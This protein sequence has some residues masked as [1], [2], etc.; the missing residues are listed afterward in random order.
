M[1]TEPIYPPTRQAHYPHLSALDSQLWDNYLALGD[2]GYLSVQYDVP[3]GE[4]IDASLLTLPKNLYM[5]ARLSAH[6]IDIVATAKDH[7]DIIECKP[8]AG[9]TALGQLIIYSQLYQSSYNP[10]LPLRLLLITNQIDHDIHTIYAAQNIKVVEV[11][12]NDPRNI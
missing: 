1:R 9:T 12:F 10:T 4:P 2:H 3:V 11:P 6:R 5:E 8:R 7:I